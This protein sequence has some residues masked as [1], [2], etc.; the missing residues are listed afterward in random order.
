MN[1]H[2]HSSSQSPSQSSSQSSSQNKPITCTIMDQIDKKLNLS[3]EKI[4]KFEKFISEEPTRWIILFVS[5]IVTYLYMLYISFI[6][7]NS[8]SEPQQQ[9][10]TAL[11][12]NWSLG[13]YNQTRGDPNSPSL[14]KWDAAECSLM[15][16][17]IIATLFLYWKIVVKQTGEKFFIKILQ[18]ILAWLHSVI[19]LFLIPVNPFHK[20]VLY[21][22]RC[23][24]ATVCN[25][26]LQ[27]LW[28]AFLFIVLLPFP[29]SYSHK[30][31]LVWLSIKLGLFYI[32]QNFLLGSPNYTVELVQED[33]TLPNT[34]LEYIGYAAFI[35]V[36]IVL[37]VR[38]NCKRA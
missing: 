35:L 37:V 32:F 1:K 19:L 22:F 30:E 7:K 26:P 12:F 9:R 18:F 38:E 10:D 36:V 25:E 15:S 17:V 8:P 31:R 5:V 20:R 2:S 3:H 27:E 11:L 16:V 13:G 23:I 21:N 6:S 33:K 28:L 14:F 4:V 24:L 29:G 34:T